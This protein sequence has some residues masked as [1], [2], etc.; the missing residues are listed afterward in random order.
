MVTS[1]TVTIDVVSAFDITVNSIYMKES[2][3]YYMGTTYHVEGSVGF[4]TAAPAGMYVDVYLYATDPSGASHTL[5]SVRIGV[6]EGAS[7]ITYE[8]AVSFNAV[9]KWSIWTDATYGR[10]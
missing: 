4:T 5:N 3:P 2:G 7:S 1:N 9:G 8:F 6:P 10:T